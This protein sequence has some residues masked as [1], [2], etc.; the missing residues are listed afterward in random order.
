MDNFSKVDKPP[1][2]SN[3]PGGVWKIEKKRKAR[4]RKSK[5]QKYVN[6]EQKIREE[7]DSVLVEIDTER[8]NDKECEDQMGYGFIK[9][10]KSLCT[11]IDLKI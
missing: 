3:T 11:R 7:D 6:S 4:D 9:K 2:I 5:Q 1:A 10:K 8:D